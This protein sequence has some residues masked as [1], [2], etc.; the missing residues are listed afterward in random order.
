VALEAIKGTTLRTQIDPLHHLAPTDVGTLSTETLRA[1]LPAGEWEEEHGPLS[2]LVRRHINEQSVVLSTGHFMEVGA[3]ARTSVVD[4]RHFITVQHG[5]LTPNAPP[6]AEGTTLLA[7]SEA[8]ADFWRSGRSDVAAHVVGSPLWALPQSGPPPVTL[9]SDRPVFLG[10]LHGAELPREAMEA[11]AHAFCVTHHADYRPH[12]SESDRRSR[13]LHAAWEAEGITID[14]SGTPL[15]EVRRPVVSV[16][17]TGVLEA[18]AHGLPAW[19]AF[20]HPPRWLEEFWD[21]YGMNQWG[22]GPTPPP[23]TPAVE[24]SVAIARVIREMMDA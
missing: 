9:E 24:P 22:Q 14:R 1:C 4:P 6:L 19:V 10:Q 13:R 12:P 2:S 23:P 20:S 11:S 3:S 18:A 7:W 8:D 17:S 5:L 16:F 15:R 21:R